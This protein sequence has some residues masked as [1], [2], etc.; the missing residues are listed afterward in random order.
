MSAVAVLPLIVA[1]LLLVATI[2]AVVALVRVSRPDPAN[3]DPDAVATV[4]PWLAATSS[5]LG[6]ALALGFLA[7]VGTALTG[8][9]WRDAPLVA[10]GVAAVVALGSLLVLPR[11]G[12]PTL[13][14]VRRASLTARD[15]WSFGPR[16]AVVTPLVLTALLVVGLGVSAAIARWDAERAS[17]GL[18][19]QVSSGYAVDADGTARV[20]VADGS[21]GPL[22]GWPDAAVAVLVVLATL[23]LAFAALRG[24]AE[25]AAL[26][27]PSLAA[28][29]A[30]VRAQETRFVV[31]VASAGLAAQLAIAALVPGGGLLMV[32]TYAQT[33][34]GQVDWVAVQPANTIGGVLVGLAVAAAFL[35]VALMG[36]ALNAAQAPRRLL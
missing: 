13:T 7:F 26:D 3:L 36:F 11:G 10:G 21:L 32:R 33:A 18:P 6:A 31:G 19:T 12:T 4:R 28:V 9:G 5:R 15:P 8:M 22:W 2:A 30:Q 14:D 24:I 35:A 34:P 17:W 29:D 27:E 1:L 16:W 25:R 20:L 23:A